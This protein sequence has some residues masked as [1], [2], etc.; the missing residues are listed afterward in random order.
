MSSPVYLAGTM[1]AATGWGVGWRRR[2]QK[3]FASH[4]EG[5]FSPP[6]R[7][8]ELLVKYDIRPSD[9]RR[10]PYRLHS[11]TRKQLFGEIVKFDLEQIRYRT[12]Y[13]VVYFTEYSPGT[14]S[15]LTWARMWGIPVYMVTKRKR[16]KPWTESCVTK[17]FRTWEQLHSFLKV[18]YGLRRNKR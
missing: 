17:T 18:R 4:G 13:V 7:E 2:E 5:T 10:Y 11:S 9:L 15:E 8:N 16:L 6:D 1:T 12:K 3:W 14:V